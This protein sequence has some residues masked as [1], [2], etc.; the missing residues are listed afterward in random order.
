[1]LSM[2]AHYE[3]ELKSEGLNILFNILLVNALTGVIATLAFFAL[4]NIPSTEWFNALFL[5]LIAELTFIIMLLV[6]KF[7]IKNTTYQSWH[8]ATLAYLSYIVFNF[9]YFNFDIASI[10]ILMALLYMIATQVLM[11]FR[12]SLLFGI[13]GLF[14]A[15]LLYTFRLG[16][17]VDIGI[18]F[19]ATLIQAL[20][21]G[22]YASYS[23]I[24]LFKKYHATLNNQLLQLL[25][26][27][28]RNILLHHASREMMW[29]YNLKT[30]VRTF[31]EVGLLGER[32]KLSQSS[33]IEDWV[34]DIHPDD[35]E[36]LLQLYLSLRDGEL[37][38]FEKEFRQLSPSG[39]E[40][41]FS[42]RVI[43]LKN[44]EGLVEKMAGAYTHIQD[45]KQKELKIEHLAF[46]DELTGLPNR[47]ALLKDFDTF[48]HGSKGSN[49]AVLFYIDIQNFKEINSSFGHGVGDQLIVAVAN[50]LK[51]SP[52]N[53]SLYQLTTVDLGLLCFGSNTVITHIAER[54]LKEFNTPFFIES[55]EIFLNVLI[56]IAAYPSSALDGESLLR[57]ADTALYHCQKMQQLSYLEYD[58]EMTDSV[59][60]RLNL[61]K[62]MRQALGNNEFHLVFQPLIRLEKENHRL[63][64]FEALLRWV[65]PQLGNVRPDHFI[66]LAEESGLI[67][68]IGRFVLL[69]SC[70]FLKEMVKIQSDIILSINL[71]AKQIGSEQFLPELLDIVQKTNVNPKNLC[72]EITET[73]FIESFESV[74]FKL[75]FLR[76]KGF[77]IALDDFGTGYSSLNYLGQLSI[78]TLKIDKSFTEKIDATLSDYYLIKSVIALAKD[79]KIDFVAEGVETENQLEQLNNIQCPIVQGYYFSKPLESEKALA[80]MSK[81]NTHSVA[82]DSQ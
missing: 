21:L 40:T 71:S 25:E 32:E 23:Y 34:L 4:A 5:P 10:L 50:R 79:L 24:N 41:W 1:M 57:N 3:D 74:Q 68:G 69:Q 62:H 13:T 78:D 37:D 46:F 54:I 67:M 30:G 22:M 64:G 82:E 42:A 39:I 35:S 65:S 2:K 33:R 8:L 73:S 31:V 19:T 45:R 17:I 15:G 70:N 58:L 53:G 66:P 20:I 9:Y 52:L 12:V 6:V 7:G 51:S 77:K 61:N 59:T 76:E 18:G 16:Q 29:D 47:T 26:S 11:D 36:E 48:V 44:S 28:E 75:N 27:E 81:M 60:H 14:I 56:G 63:Y 72:L 43:S 80:F 49:E 38:Y 55:K